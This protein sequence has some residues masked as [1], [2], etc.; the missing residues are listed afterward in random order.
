MA[1]LNKASYAHRLFLWLVLYSC[2]LGGCLII[3][4]YFREKKYKADEFNEA[5]QVV[6][7]HIL[8]GYGTGLAVDFAKEYSIDNLRVSIIDL[9]GNVL[10]DNSLDSLPYTDHRQREEIASALST[11]TGY[12]VR[13][14]SDTTGDTYFY[15]ARREG[16]FIVR[17]AVPYS[18]TLLELLTADMSFLWIMFAIIA[19]MCVIGYF[20]TRRLGLHVSRLKAFAAKAE[21]G[22]RI[23]DTTSFPH[24]ELGDIS[25]TIVRL[26][27]KLQQANADRDKEH[28]AAL[29]EA[30]GKIEIKRRL[31]NN[32]N[33]ELKTPLAS[34]SVCLESIITHKNMPPEKQRDFIERCYSNCERLRKLLDDASLITRLDEGGEIIAKDETDIAEIVSEVCDDMAAI[35]SER[36][37]ELINRLDGSLMI[38]GNRMIISSIFYNLISNAISYS[39]GS[40]IEI[41]PGD[42]TPQ[43]I[44][45]IFRDNGYGVGDEHIDHIF[46]RFYRVDKGRSRRLGGTGLGLSIVK[47]GIAFHHGTIS[48]E[49]LRSGGLQFTMTFGRN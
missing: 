33:H 18:V 11:G 17:T 30:H 42:V 1:S 6:N 26:Y 45:I 37:F 47:N 22:E 36:G 31:T 21:R 13:R 19:G 39:G 48:A 20:A 10:Y 9:N 12:S 38:S 34:M 8:S 16:D 35:A 2:L 24:D 14:V 32:I 29:R 40:V 23:Y 41:I 27:A 25:S 28:A 43:K 15:S 44:T 3:F 49:N 4:Q 5:L 7:N 46:E